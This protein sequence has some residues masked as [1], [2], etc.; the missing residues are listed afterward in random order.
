MILLTAHK[1]SRSSKS[2]KSYF[3]FQS[4]FYSYYSLTTF[5]KWPTLIVINGIRTRDPGNASCDPSAQL[6]SRPMQF[7]HQC[8]PIW[9]PTADASPTSMT[10]VL[11]D[12]RSISPTQRTFK[13]CGPSTGHQPRVFFLVFAISFNHFKRP[14]LRAHYIGLS[15][16]GA[17]TTRWQ[18]R[19]RMKSF[20]FYY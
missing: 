5:L 10:R 12:S 4:I 7:L 14:T 9:S 1:H 2:S 20:C 8:L 16:W 18:Y 17:F 15:Q 6:L 3:V 11:I 13:N 19:S